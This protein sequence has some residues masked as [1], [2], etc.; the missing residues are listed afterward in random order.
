MKKLLQI[1]LAIIVMLLIAVNTA[2]ANTGDKAPVSKEN[3]LR[4]VTDEYSKTPMVKGEPITSGIARKK[5][6]KENAKGSGKKSKG[7]YDDK[8]IPIDIAVEEICKRDKLKDA[9]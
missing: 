3:K 9:C 6:S 1:L 5:S 8:L 4:S 2:S 7:V